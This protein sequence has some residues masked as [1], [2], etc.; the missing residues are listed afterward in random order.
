VNAL[1]VEVLRAIKGNQILA[2]IKLIGALQFLA[3]LKSA[4]VFAEHPF[5]GTV[6]MLV[7]NCWLATSLAPASPGVRGFDA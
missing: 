2:R 5:Q 3:A 7:E 4:E 1:A 6:L